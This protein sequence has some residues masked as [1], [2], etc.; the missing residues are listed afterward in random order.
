M[1]CCGNKNGSAGIE[2]QVKCN[3]GTVKTVATLAEVRVA[4]N[5]NGGGS[6]K[7]VPKPVAK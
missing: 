4:L 7:S 3:N 6:Y 5:T 1:G 2:Y